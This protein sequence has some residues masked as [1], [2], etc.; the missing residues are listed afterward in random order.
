MDVLLGRLISLGLFRYLGV[1]SIGL[2]IWYMGPQFE[3]LRPVST[4]LIVI[5][6]IAVGFFA[7]VLVKKYLDKRKSAQLSDDLAANAESEIDQSQQRSAEEIAELKNKFDDAIKT[8]RKSGKGKQADSLYSL[9]WYM[10]IGPPGSGKTTLLVNSGLRF[11]LAEKM[12]IS[13]LQGVGG[14]R[15]CDWWFTDEAV[16]VDTAGR[17]TT[18]DSDEQVDN[19]AWTG[20]L[21][22]LKKNRKRR[23]I[24]GIVVAIS[25][26]ELSR[27]SE[28]DR[29]RTANAVTQRIQ[30]LYEQLGVRFPVYVMF[31]KCDLLAGFMEFFSDLDRHQREQVWGTT[32]PLEGDP[33]DHLK[34][35]LHLLQEQIE[36]RLVQRLQEERDPN[37]R[38]LIYNF[39]SLFGA[40]QPLAVEFMERVFKPS[41]YTM[42]PFLR[43]VYF[44]SGTQEGTPFNRLISQLARSF[45]L[46]NKSLYGGPAKGKSFF[47]RDLLS[48]VIFGESGLAGANL[49]AERVYGLVRTAGFVALAIV[50]VLLIGLWWMSAS[51]NNARMDEL[52]TDATALEETISQVTPMNRSMVSIL[53]LMNQSRELTFGYADR[54]ASTPLSLRFGLYQGNRLAR[55]LTVP[56]YKNVLE[57]AFLSRLMLRVE[58]QMKASMNNP[59]QAYYALKV[60]LMLGNDERLDPEFVRTW[61]AKAWEQQFETGISREQYAQLLLHLDALLD[62]RPFTLPYAPDD[63]LVETMR[64]VLEATSH[65]QRAYAMI[66]ASMLTEGEDFSLA[67][68]GGPDARLALMRPSG[69]RF[70][71]G[72]P[73]MFSPDAYYKS[74]IPTQA[75]VIDEQQEEFWIFGT[76]AM[77]TSQPD[78][79]DLMQQVANIYFRDY[80]ANWWQFLGDIRIQPFSNAVEAAEILRVITGDESPLVL[81]LRG[82]A[83]RTKL[84][85][86]IPIPGAGDGESEEGSSLLMTVGDPGVVD[87]EFR[88]L[89]DFVLGKG[90]QPPPLMSINDDIQEL[91]Y[92]IDTLAREGMGAETESA[93][94]QISGIVNKIKFASTK[95]PEP[96]SSMIGDMAAQGDGLVAGRFMGALNIRWKSEVVPF[97]QKAISNRYPFTAG[98]EREVA[99]QDFGQFFGRGGKM[100]QFFDTNL[101]RFVDTNANPWR[102]H[103]SEADVIQVNPS[104]LRQM[105]QAKAIQNAF[106]AGGGNLPAT[107]FSLTPVR[108]DA[109]TTHFT[110]NLNGQQISYGHDLPRTEAL[111]WPSDSSYT[112]VQILFAPPT[113]TGGSLTERGDW[114]W[115]RLLDKSNLQPGSA[116]EIFKLTFSLDDRWI[117]YELRARSA[118]NPFNLSQLRSFRCVPSL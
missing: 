49:K 113:A 78:R 45:S 80:I 115:F 35:E 105:Q 111:L 13:K 53:P 81:V 77:E 17:Y 32:F 26:D 5:G 62:L 40:A 90:D 79:A 6:I 27:Q 69:E 51:N 63:N 71:S 84:A 39:P 24:N 118:Y 29:E 2:L 11:P 25:V 22:L 109:Q 100:D 56:T 55:N 19:A 12:G 95:A 10:I 15:F 74:F 93:Q 36:A 37:R 99:L 110:L 70:S 67:S 61:V 91:A 33:L 85:P 112:Q 76:N 87:R 94:K 102:I 86:D 89:H 88:P 23:P 28:V 73:A 114:A 47:I 98:S 7:Y 9:P 46:S 3:F 83:E 92:Y 116:P 82:T 66:K 20:F 103:A 44:T 106:F 16:I 14:T 68:A 108:M 58:Q 50:P 21:K 30:E 57:N 104:A 34:T 1:G 4:R 59:E 42:T 117:D 65:A 48:K 75:R 97:C 43:G 72:V 18:Q 31:T 8:L 101:A 54:E 107:S 52:A 60:Y 96:V 41:R 64:G 38:N